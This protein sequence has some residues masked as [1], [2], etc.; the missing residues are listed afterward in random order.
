[1]DQLGPDK[2]RG[3]LSRALHR[4]RSQSAPHVFVAGLALDDL[5][6]AVVDKARLC[7]L[8]GYGIALGCKI[9]RAHV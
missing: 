2:A 6:E 5:P 1:M 9:G 3:A 4:L 8:N 7:L